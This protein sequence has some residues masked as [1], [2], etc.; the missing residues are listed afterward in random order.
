M[1]KRLIRD[2]V[3]RFLAVGAAI[4]WITH[5]LH[6][7][8]QNTAQRIVVDAAQV[9]RLSQL[10]QA[11][12]G[13][14]ASQVEIDHL[15]D[16]Y[17]HDEVLY[18]E[19]LRLGL[20][21][22]DDIVRR[23]LVQKIE[24]LNSDLAAAA[25]PS[26]T[27]LRRYYSAHAAEFAAPA[28]VTFSHIYFAPDLRGEVSARQAALDALRA[29]Q[30]Q[31]NPAQRQVGDPFPLQR[32]YAELSAGEVAQ[33]FGHTPFVAALFAAPVGQWWGPIRSGYGW[34][35]VFV[36][37]RVEQRIPEFENIK[38]QVAAA[39]AEELRRRADERGYAEMEARYFVVREY[40]AQVR[41]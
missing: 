12:T 39:A 14:A 24:F 36:S 33:V 38:A 30:T 32:T 13:A 2:P 28:A 34:H 6:H 3:V 5:L 37:H 26:E 10:Y 16:D 22:N 7:S 31:P 9:R 29:L 27:E 21:Q 17:I 15:V 40:A 20:D 19:A 11:Q 35:L 25:P 18:R 1:S 41:R 8:S 4:F 23:R